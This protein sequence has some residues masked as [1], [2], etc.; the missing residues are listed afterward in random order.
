[1]LLF[2]YFCLNIRLNSLNNNFDNYKG[3]LTIF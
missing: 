3:F 1:M 2:K